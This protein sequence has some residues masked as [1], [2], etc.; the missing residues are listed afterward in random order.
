MQSVTKLVEEID[1]YFAKWKAN[2]VTK[3]GKF[4]F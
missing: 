2:E 1:R 3:D 4:K